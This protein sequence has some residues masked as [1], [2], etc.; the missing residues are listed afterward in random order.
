[1]SE[2]EV[3]RLMELS[4]QDLLMATV[5]GRGNV[6]WREERSLCSHCKISQLE[7]QSLGLSAPNQKVYLTSVYQ[8]S[9]KRCTETAVEMCT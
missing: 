5:R 6:W 9:A 7:E 3:W 2:L 1:M 8:Y 4:I